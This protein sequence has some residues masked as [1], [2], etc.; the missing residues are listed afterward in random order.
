MV[1]RKFFDS[2]DL[3]RAQTLYIY[4]LTDIIIINKNK[5]L[6]FVVI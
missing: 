3:I 5:N 4:K 6:V 2:T 1:M